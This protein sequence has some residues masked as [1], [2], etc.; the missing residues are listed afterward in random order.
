MASPRY[1]ANG[2]YGCV[3]RPAV[4]CDNASANASASVK[5]LQNQTAKVSK[6]F[7]SLR[8]A[9][10]EFEMQKMMHKLD[11]KGIFTI[12]SYE[13]CIIARDKIKPAEL[14]KCEE[15]SSFKLKY[16]QKD[17]THLHQIVFDDGGIDLHDNFHS[18]ISEKTGFQELFVAMHSLFEGL[19]MLQKSKYTHMDIKPANIVY[20]RT[21]KKM[22]LID[23]GKCEE[24]KTLYTSQGKLYEYLYIY[25]PPEFV[26][27]ANKKW[28][29][30][31]FV[32]MM[33]KFKI[34][35]QYFGQE[36]EET[37]LDDWN[38]LI[39]TVDSS[40]FI[41]KNWAS[42]IDVY[43]LGVTL[44][45]IWIYLPSYYI[46][47]AM[48]FVDDLIYLITGMIRLHPEKRFTPQEARDEYNNI[49]TKWNLKNDM[50]KFKSPR[51]EKIDEPSPH[52]GHGHD[53]DLSKIKLKSKTQVK[54][55][56]TN[57]TQSKP[58]EKPCPPG[59]E[60]DVLSQKRCRKKCQP[61]QERNP[62]TNRCRKKQ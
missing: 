46:C 41:Q 59:Q 7:T 38:E 48:P 32:K 24:Q 8:H 26:V 35:D 49:I 2:T 61:G 33:K 27:Y 29:N 45:E 5:T 51:R 39:E 47:N 37:L 34:I 23:F 28:D 55:K 17:I 58:K 13:Q 19:I 9:K 54:S 6:V 25:F 43:S 31:N 18:S 56:D 21:T 40:D 4:E 16:K 3:M 30:Q 42:A 62:V 44:L 12:K 57:I 15:S 1:V 52:G 11:P 53:I 36:F 14:E 10:E 60:R 50:R 20:N 22:S